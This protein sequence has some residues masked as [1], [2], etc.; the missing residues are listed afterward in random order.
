MIMMKVSKVSITQP[1]ALSFSGVEGGSCSVS[2]SG[3]LT[4]SISESWS[5]AVPWSRSR[6]RHRS[7]STIEYDGPPLQP[8]DYLL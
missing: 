1:K 8:L 6:V 7:F 3:L 2:R 4:W 5:Q